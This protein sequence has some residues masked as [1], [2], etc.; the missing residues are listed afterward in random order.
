MALVNQKRANLGTPT[1]ETSAELVAIA[2]KH[3][4]DMAARDCFAHDSPEGDTYL[5]RYREV[6]FSCGRSVDRVIHQGAENIYQGWASN[7]LTIRDWRIVTIKVS[8]GQALASEAVREW[9]QSPGH[10]ANFLHPVWGQ[11]GIEV[12]VGAGNNV[13]ITHNFC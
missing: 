7:S 6:G 5:D 8:N 10:R 2:T 12:A 1:L 9:M 13:N 4:E 11:Q 3:S